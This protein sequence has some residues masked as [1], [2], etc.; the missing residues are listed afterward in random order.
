MDY[1]FYKLVYNDKHKTYRNAWML[2]SKEQFIKKMKNNGHTDE[3]IDDI[4][5]TK[6]EIEKDLHMKVGY[7]LFLTINPK[8]KIKTLN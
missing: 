1:N 8:Y 6:E 3:S 7:E 5:K 2:M 4:L